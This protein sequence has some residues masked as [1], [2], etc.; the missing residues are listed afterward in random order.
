MKVSELMKGRELNPDFADITT[1][2]DWVLAIKTEEA[3]TTEND[4]TVVQGGV[5]SH[6]ASINS[7]TSDSQYVR[8]GKQTTRTDAQRQFA[9]TGDRMIADPA[10]E[11]LLSLGMKFGTGQSV[12]VPYVY[13]NIFTGKGEKG[14]VTVNVTEDQGGDAGG[15]STFAIDLMGTA[16]PEEYTYAAS[17]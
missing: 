2:D 6:A 11:F 16:K 7:E 10:Q 4:Y 13:F 14:S 5:T 9:V 17:E 12:V 8:T 3:Q 15:N 1:N